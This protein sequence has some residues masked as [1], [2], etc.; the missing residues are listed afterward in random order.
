MVVREQLWCVLDCEISKEESDMRWVMGA[1][2]VVRSG[3][4]SNDL[5]WTIVEQSL[6]SLI[7]KNITGTL[8]LIK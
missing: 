6:W 8:I 1:E 4:Y 2:K 3:G 7:S 5:F